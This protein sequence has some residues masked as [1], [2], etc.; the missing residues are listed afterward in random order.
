MPKVLSLFF[1]IFLLHFKFT[2][3]LYF[4]FIFLF[5]NVHNHSKTHHHS[6]KIFSFAFGYIVNILT[7]KNVILTLLFHCLTSSRLLL[8]Q[9]ISKETEKILFLQL[10]ENLLMLLRKVSLFLCTKY[11]G[12]L[13]SFFPLTKHNSHFSLPFYYTILISYPF[14]FPQGKPTK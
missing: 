14:T 7:Q 13:L 4:F 1:N 2:F 3:I 11:L 8:Q 5:N 10:I 6:E 9:F 12:I